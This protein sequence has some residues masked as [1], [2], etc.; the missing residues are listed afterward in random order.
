MKTI[1]LRFSDGFAPPTGTIA[2]H[3]RVISK[4][5]YVWYG[6]LG[7]PVSDRVYNDLIKNEEPKILLIH[8]GK[9]SRYWAYIDQMIKHTPPLEDIPDY[10]RNQAENFRT[11]FR[12]LKI[13]EAEKNVMAACSVLSSGV[14]LSVASKSSMSPYFI[15][16]YTEGGE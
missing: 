13:E 5:G 4:K 7:L 8:S 11:W 3:R 14:L 15:I 16:N 6:K 12:V 9:S 1:A 2:E 10:Y